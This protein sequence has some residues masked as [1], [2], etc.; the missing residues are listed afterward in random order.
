MT[1]QNE[2]S[3]QELTG[4]RQPSSQNVSG[5]DKHNSNSASQPQ[6]V[7]GERLTR[8]EKMLSSIQS[9]KDRAVDKTRSEVNDLR[10][11]LSDV[12][13]L[14]KKGLSEDEAFEQLEGRKADNEFKQAVLE[15]RDALKGGKSLPVQAN[16]AKVEPSVV[17]VL[18]QFPDLDAN[19]PDVIANVLSQQ[20]PDKAELAA[21]RLIR[22]RA[23]QPSPTAAGAIEGKPPA[24]APDQAALVSE[25]RS[26]QLNPTKNMKRMGEIEKILGW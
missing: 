16:G 26:L 1:D 18:K 12:Q 2:D 19:D 13:S 3:G 6:D 22:K 8:I 14:M 9:G 4:S 10:K 15:L 11:S 21:S 5:G 23:S 25:L 20:D 24:P 17:E 7:L